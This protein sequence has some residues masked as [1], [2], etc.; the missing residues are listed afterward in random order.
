MIKK[1]VY[2]IP[3]IALLVLVRQA[4]AGFINGG[5]E[6]GDFTG[7]TLEHGFNN[8]GTTAFTPGDAG[9]A[10]VL[11]AGYDDPYSSFDSPFNGNYMA[12][13]N[14]FN[15][16]TDA[17]RISQTGTM[18]ADETDVFINWGAVVED[19]SHAISSQPYFDITILRNGVL[20]ANEKH[21]AS[22]GATGGWLAGP[23]G[24]NFSPTYYSSGVFHVSGLTASDQVT[25]LMT[26]ADC[27]LGAHSGWAYLDGI[28]T[29][30]QPPGQDPPDSH[31]VPDAGSSVML[32]GMALAGIGGIRHKLNI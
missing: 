13:L 14:E 25:V 12:R 29:V 15:P 30:Q 2:M 17:T 26:A 19:P 4:S 20:F 10:Y 7:W 22:Q 3:A 27:A 24:P 1:Y 6:T 32:L 21:N 8:N 9:H 31:G 18:L 11:G 5:F 28:G 16:N 23:T